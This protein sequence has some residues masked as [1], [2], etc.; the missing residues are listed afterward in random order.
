MYCIIKSLASIK[1]DYIAHLKKL[2]KG[3]YFQ[4]LFLFTCMRKIS[5]KD[6]WLQSAVRPL[7]IFFPLSILKDIL[8]HAF[9]GR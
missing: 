2:V 8:Y 9:Q 1:I 4:A 6:L 7:H 3:N 5:I